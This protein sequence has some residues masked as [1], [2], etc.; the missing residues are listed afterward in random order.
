MKT[1]P[2]G[3]EQLKVSPRE[4][5]LKTSPR[6]VP[7]VSPRDNNET[8]ELAIKKVET[9]SDSEFDAAHKK[10]KNALDVDTF[11]TVTAQDN[12]QFRKVNANSFAPMKQTT[13]WQ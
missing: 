7:K 6:Y 4:V 9:I 12:A 1:S 3:T 2:R 11:R 13:D 10:E 8:G 5:P